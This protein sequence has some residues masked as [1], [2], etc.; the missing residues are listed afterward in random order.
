MQARAML[1]LL[2]CVIVTPSAA[3]VLVPQDNT[4]RYFKGFSEASVPDSSAWRELTFDEFG[5]A[6]SQAAFYYENQPG[7]A[8][9]F[10]GNTALSDMFGGYTCIFL[11]RTFVLNNVN[12]IAALQVAGRSD[13][14]F[15]AWINGHEVARFNMPEGEVAYSGGS[16]PALSEPISWWTN[17]LSGL[18]TFLMP[19]SN[20]LAVQAFNSSIG[21]SSDFIINAALY[22]TADVSGPIMT[23]SYPAT[24][25]LVRELTYVEIAFNEPVTGIEAG[26]L[27]INGQPA[28]NLTVLTPS[29]FLFSFPQPPAGLVQ[30]AWAA[31]HGIRDLSNASNLFAGGS[32]SFTLNPN[33]PPPGVMIS[34]FM[35]SNSGD[36]LNSVRDDL[37]NAPDWIELYNS[38][39]SV[40]SL[41]GWSLTD[42][43]GNLTKWQFPP[44]LLP[45]NSYLVVFASD[46]NTNVAGQLH[47][48][49][50]L[51]ASP[52]FL[53]L[54]DSVG[55]V[56]S[57]FTPVYPQQYTDVSYGR[58]RLDPSLLGYFT[59]ATPGT[60]NTN[61]GAG[62]GPEVQFS[63]AAGTFVTDFALALTAADTNCDIRYELVTTNL[64][65]GITAITNLPTSN[66]PLYSAPITINNSTQVRARAFPRQSGFWPGPPKSE[67][68]VKIS[69]VAASFGSDLPVIVLHNLGGGPLSAGAPA[70]DQSVIV[71]VFEPVNG[72]SSL[73]NPPTRVARGGFNIRGS[74]T[75]GLPQYNLALE[76]WDEY[77]QDNSLDLLGMP[78]ES[79]WVLFAQNNFDPSYLH[80]PLMHQLSRE[81]GLP[82]IGSAQAG[83]YSARTRFAEVFLNTAG[84]V[85]NYVSPAGGNYFG[86][87]TIE[88]KIKRDENRVNIAKLEPQDTVAPMV[89]GG[90]LLKIDRADSDERTFYDSFLQ[91]SIV[92]QEPPGPEMVNAAR[93]A[94]YNYITTTFSQFGAALW[95][96]NYTNPLTG[97]AAHI[98]VDSWVDHHILNVLSFNVDALRLSGFFFKDRER[99][100]EMGPL[101]DFDRSLGSTD[102]RAFNPRLWRVQAGGDQGTDFFGNPSL[103]GVRWWQRLFTDPD[104]WQRW[105]DRWSELRG[106]VFA[107]NH[108]FAR[109]DTLGNQ[110]RQAQIR[111]VARWSGT[112][113]GTTPRSG[114]ASVNGYSHTFSGG[115]QGELNFLK[116]WLADRVDF[117]DTNFLRAPVFSGNGG[118]ITSGFPLS[119]IATNVRP[120]TT[121]YYT[122]NGTDPRL[123]G[124]AINPAASFA[125]APINLFLTNNA[126]IFARNYNPAHSNMTGGAVGGN[127]PI[128]TPWSG[129]RIATFVV[130]IPP[131]A[132]TEIM[133][134]PA[135]PASGTNESGDFE[136]IEL[137]NVGPQ[138]LS[139]VG[140][141]F[142]NGITFTFTTTNAITNLGPNQYLV[143]VKNRPAFLSRYPTVTNVAGEFTGSLDDAGERLALEGALKEPI[144]DFSFNDNWY[145][146][147]DGPGFSL[148]IRNEGAAFSSWTNPAS[149]RASAL[150]GGS[151]G[152]AD[153]AAPN[154]AAI[155]VNEALTHTDPPQVDSIELYNPTGSPQ[156]L[157]GWFLTDDADEPMKYRIPTN[158]VI[159]AG[160]Y[161][162]FTENEFGPGGADAFGLSSLGEEI[163][164][165]SG[166]GTNIT[167]YRHGFE[168]GAQTNGVAFGRHVTS[169]GVEHFVTPEANTLSFANAGPKVGPIIISEIM[170]APP[171][172]ASNANTLEEYIELRNLAGQP[173]PLFDPLHPTNA[174]RLD[175]G[176]QFTFPAGVEIPPQSYL[177]VVNFNPDF[178]PV[179]LNWFRARYGL[180]T[181]TPLFGPYEGNLANEGER[182][183]LYMP[184]KPEVPPSPVVGFVPYVA[185][186]AVNYSDHLPW[187]VGANGTGNSLQRV[188]SIAFG[189]DPAHWQAGAPTP[190][191]LN[192]NALVVDTDFDGL[193]DEWE[194]ANGFDPRNS[195][196]LNGPLGDPDGDGSGNL[197]EYLAGTDPHDD[198]DYLQLWVNVSPPYCA[199]SFNTRAGRTYAIEA[200]TDL[201]VTN[202]WS[203]VAGGIGGNGTPAI[204]NDPLGA[205]ARFYRLKVTPN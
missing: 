18:Q 28:T 6:T 163:Y 129:P 166:D 33:A 147:T 62:F 193:P 32:W 19:G 78:A 14:G 1:L 142:T 63:R 202:V 183:A 70:E 174:W 110:A 40:V 109:V 104:F 191:R 27:R 180:S 11:R 113:S 100:I 103:L 52:G 44:T 133:Y 21:G 140:M 172:F 47:T 178:D 80:N 53:G 84:G 135:P 94:Q 15:I 145:P 198:Q 75:A 57:A 185:V 159:L 134:H 65:Y 43:P 177:L 41:T 144:L 82:A 23:L 154:I 111:N 96:G 20:V 204:V 54:V 50:K 77:N 162:V 68:Y 114:T 35:A 149:W 167:G 29:Q 156:N 155:L 98:D 171:P 117:I 158:T 46:R 170:Y 24:N 95:G 148:V 85:L 122:R 69:A 60:A 192:Q 169:D 83:R 136:F 55:N 34:E 25:A 195:G 150:P 143:L 130:A 45:G 157:G 26:D 2:G 93:Q 71:M 88:E 139:L 99:K 125:A 36:Q 39:G 190:G 182:V 8:N 112:G 17:T 87:Y 31:G 12:D 51:S 138:P 66:S 64:A 116:R 59:N 7:S 115:Y 197:H 49:F 107:T 186:E 105:V 126:R 141:C 56:I 73:T 194:L 184:D 5:W 121:T 22:Y 152:R 13:D 30:V 76:F 176:V 10:T 200:A 48:N 81:V 179:M 160:G 132:I 199:L 153:P 42:N 108:L 128:S 189:D 61:R 58:D 146:T 181:N 131:L 201:G 173:A 137:K 168:F 187:P 97:Y 118:A 16:S 175:G 196:G 86:L 123:P 164:L 124:G 89:T 205:T 91:G 90:Y 37:G 9:A 67:S 127:P 3:V 102:S 101:W 120:N 119:I 74:S 72:R 161:R 151:P 79:D 203:Q 165:F 106:G 188:A 92:F 4:W 38:S